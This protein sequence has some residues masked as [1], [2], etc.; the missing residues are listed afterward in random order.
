MSDDNQNPVPPSVVPPRAVPPAASADTPTVR[1]QPVNGGVPAE[2]A[3]RTVRLRAVQAPPV[4]APASTPPAAPAAASA[5]N[6]VDAV[7][8]L[9]SMTTRLSPIDFPEATPPSNPNIKTINLAL[10]DASPAA[11]TNTARIQPVAATSPIPSFV[12]GPKTV[13]IRPLV[14]QQPNTGATQNMTITPAAADV[15]L[16]Q[17]SKKSKTSRIPLEAAAATSTPASEAAGTPKTIKLRRSADMTTIKMAVPTAPGSA[18]SESQDEANVSPSQK[19]TIRVKRPSAPITV[20]MGDNDG[21]GA[22]EG[23]A[24]HPA[25]F[26]APAREPMSGPFVAVAALCIVTT[27]VLM[28]VYASEIFGPSA[29]LTQLSAG[30]PS[31]EINL[32]GKITPAG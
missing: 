28:V 2:E 31:I 25:M 8:A 32:P 24:T 12:D 21:D 29:S 16:P 20:N 13:K 5:T 7:T 4:S 3:P 17:G 22:S 19:K 10:A 26:V 30:A 27:I 14:G 6:S 1:R 15:P 9:K 18:A 23:A 11:R